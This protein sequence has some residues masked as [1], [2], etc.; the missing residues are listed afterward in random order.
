MPQKGNNGENGGP[1]GDLIIKVN[2]KPDQFFQREGFDIVT[3]QLIT[4]TEAV[5]GTKIKV[6]TLAGEREIEVKPGTQHGEMIKIKGLG[7]N[8]LPPH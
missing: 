5:L 8:H 6:R 3:S 2:V 7:I 4:P 1:S